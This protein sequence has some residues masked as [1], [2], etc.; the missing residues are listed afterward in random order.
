MC[1]PCSG[2]ISTSLP[3]IQQT[4][5]D[6]VVHSKPWDGHPGGEKKLIRQVHV[7]QK[8]TTR[9]GNTGSSSTTYSFSWHLWKI[10][11]RPGTEGH[12]EASETCRTQL[13]SQSRG[14]DK[15]TIL[16]KHR[17]VTSG[18]RRGVSTWSCK[19]G[20]NSEESGGLSGRHGGEHLYS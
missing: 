20:G 6:Y 18:L 11:S 14:E 10:Y 12:A 15:H 9:W 17:A 4:A 8:R 1:L 19:T 5:G 7:F 13:T 2:P 16:N 3:A